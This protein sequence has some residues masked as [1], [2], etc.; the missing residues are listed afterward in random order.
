MQHRQIDYSFLGK[1]EN[2]VERNDTVNFEF[3]TPKFGAYYQINKTSSAFASFAIANREP[4][5]SDFVESSPNSRPLHE[6][7]Y[8]T[9]LGYKMGG[10]NFTF[11]TTA[12][13][14][15]YENQLILT[16]KINDVGAYTRENVNY[17]E[18]KGIELEVGVKINPKWSWSANAT[19]SK[20]LLIIIPNT[21]IIGT[22]GGKKVTATPIQL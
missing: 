4:N 7:L 2:G 20:T 1:D 14:M 16:G 10:S 19:F 6:T 21:W 12:Y 3:L 18:R 8:D 11:S 15:I 22:L 17:S 13:Y 9:E 5:R